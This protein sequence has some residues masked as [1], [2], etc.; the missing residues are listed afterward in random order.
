MRLSSCAV[1]MADG[2]A[3]RD[4]DDVTPKP[5]VEVSSGWTWKDHV[6]H[7]FAAIFGIA[8]IIVTVVV[9]LGLAVTLWRYFASLPDCNHPS[10]PTM[11][12]YCL[13]NAP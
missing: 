6:Y 9:A 1:C 2:V 12:E 3:C 10:G 5:V 8:Y 11:Y 13:E 4:H 7:V